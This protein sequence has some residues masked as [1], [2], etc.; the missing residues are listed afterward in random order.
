MLARI[1]GIFLGSLLLATPASAQPRQPSEED[2]MMREG[3]I[4]LAREYPQ[5]MRH[6]ARHGGFGGKNSRAIAVA[7]QSDAP[8]LVKEAK[9]KMTI[10][11]YG[12]GLWLLRF[13]WVNVTLIETKNS[14]ILFDSGYASMGPVLRE[15]IPTLSAKPLAHIVLSHVHIDH[16]YGAL[17]LKQKWPKAKIVASDLWPKMVAKE[18]R[19]GGSI[20]RYNNQ[21]VQFHPHKIEQLPKADIMFRD[22]LELDIDG[23]K[24]VFFHHPAETEEQIWMWAPKRKA[25]FTADYYQGFLP[26]AGNGKRM[27]RFID[28]WAAAFR[29]MA[30][31]R[32]EVMLPMHN[33]AVLGEE[34][35]ANALTLNAE[36]LE[37]I[38]K[39]V[40]ERLNNGERQDAIAASLD[41]PE[42]FAKAP[43]L[44]PQYNR[45]EDIA[46]MVMK[47]WSGWWDD[48]PSHM[49]AMPFE[50]EAKEALRLAGGV[51]AVDKRAR[52]LLPDNPK[53]AARLA[54][55]AQYGAPD[56]PVAL[57][58]AIDVYMARIAEADMPVQEGLIYFDSAA[59]ARSRLKRLNAVTKESGNPK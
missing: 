34:K 33:A 52:E 25:I 49:A 36:A 40:V 29:K 57:K 58:L 55:W 20:A 26:N 32:P 43:L 48:I 7:M 1:F 31:L 28:E 46:R 9:A 17:A 56:D 13:P 22:K 15:V 14:L 27:L 35:I 51:K 47:R 59:K 16:A 5:V 37:H 54:D 53:L 10:E 45:P 44:D 38:S 4:L 3:R 50:E 18:V 6:M 21:P 11:K 39:Q 8:H 2:L 41:W 30:S 12:Q 24:F 42:E 19:L 23:E